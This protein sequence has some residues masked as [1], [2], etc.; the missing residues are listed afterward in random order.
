MEEENESEVYSE[1]DL[2][3]EGEIVKEIPVV[4]EQTEVDQIEN[5]TLITED[6]PIEDEKKEEKKEEKEEGNLF[7]L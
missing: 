4:E 7:E 3:E 5:E 2:D 6:K 1:K